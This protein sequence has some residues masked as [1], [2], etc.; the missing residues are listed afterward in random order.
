MTQSS[1]WA[2]ITKFTPY[3][4]HTPHIILLTCRLQG[5]VYADVDL[6]GSSVAISN[7]FQT[8]VGL[9]IKRSEIK[10]DLVIE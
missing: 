2:G 7:I 8:A 1:N 10:G 5:K 6:L 4:P 3:T 9:R